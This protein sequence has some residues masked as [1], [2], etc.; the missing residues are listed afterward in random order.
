M[1]TTVTLL[2][3]GHPGCYPNV[4]QS[5]T[6]L[7]VD[8]MSIVIDC[9]GGTVQRLAVARAAG[10]PALAF[11]N[12]KTLIITHLHPDHTAGLADFLLTTWIL[13]RKEPLRIY[14]PAGTKEMTDLLVKAYKLGIAEHRDTESPT[15]WPLCYEVIEFTEGELFA[16]DAVTVTAFQ[17]SHGGL[18]TYGLKFVVGDKTIVHSADTCPHPAVIEHGQDCDLLIHEVYS[19]VGIQTPRPNNPLN[20]FRRMHTSTVEL[21]EIAEKIRP[22]K[23]ILNHQ[24]HLGAVTDE[25]LLKEITDR[26]DGEVIFGRDL[27]VF[28]V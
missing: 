11:S 12:L 27:D 8:G 7:V 5:A 9:G 10:Q 13:G 2:G 24:M 19:E 17:V 16:T 28:E 15:S 6:A 25:A 3:T 21:A 4:Y 14:G 1:S 22:K 26:Y 23:L 18:E 20:Y